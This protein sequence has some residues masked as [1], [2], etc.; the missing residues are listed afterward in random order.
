MSDAMRCDGDA[1]VT[2]ALRVF[3][4]FTPASSSLNGTAI[5]P[6]VPVDETRLRAH[7]VAR[8]LESAA[9][10]IATKTIRLIT[11]VKGATG[12]ILSFDA[13]MS[14]ACLTT[15]TVTID[16]KKNGTTILSG[17]LN[18]ANT[19]AANTAK[20]IAS[21][22]TSTSLVVGD[23]IDAVI[24]ASASGGTL[25]AGFSCELRWAEDPQ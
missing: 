6:S 7:H 24:T 8:Y 1:T 16:I 13:S 15:A 14:T 4:T 9:T 18:F 25:G 2:G 11:K 23:Y 5:N 17:T 21:L 20:N 12:K 10:T 3:G 19:D 22:L